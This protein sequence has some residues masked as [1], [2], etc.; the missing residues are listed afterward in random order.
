[1]HAELDVV[2]LSSSD[3][4]EALELLSL[5]P[6]CGVSSQ[7]SRGD[8]QEPSSSSDV[9]SDLF[10][11]WLEG[12]DMATSIYVAFTTEALSSHAPMANTSHKRKSRA[13][14]SSS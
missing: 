3:T 10:E 6:N 7:P 4:E 8:G 1:M 13:Q 12:N 14:S 11:D 9:G 5:S 2:T